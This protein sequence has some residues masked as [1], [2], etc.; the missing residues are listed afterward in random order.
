MSTL[1]RKY[2]LFVLCYLIAF[3]LFSQAKFNSAKFFVSFI[4]KGNTDAI[5]TRNLSFLSEA[6]LKRRALQNIPIEWSDYPVNQAYINQLHDEG[7]IVLNRSR[8]FNAVSVYCSDSAEIEKLKKLSFV[9]DVKPV[10][11]VLSSG[12]KEQKQLDHFKNTARLKSQISHVKSN[13]LLESHYGVSRYQTEQIDLHNLHAMGLKGQGIS[14]AVLDA[15]FYNCDRIS[16]FDSLRVNGQIL[17]TRDFV[18]GNDSVYEDNSHGM[19]VLSC[20]AAHSPNQFIGTAPKANYWLLRT[21]DAGSEY[22]IEEDNWVAAAEF[23]DSAGVWI[24]N[25]SLGYTVFDDPMTS[26]SY[27]DMDGNTTRI[28]KGADIAATKGILVVNSA[29]NSG[30]NSWQYIGAPADADSVLSIGAVDSLGNYAEFSSRGPS[31]DGRIKPNV[32]AMGQATWIVTSSGAIGKANGT[33]FSSPIIAGA[34]ACLWQAFPDAGNMEIYKA[35]EQSSHQYDA[36]DYKL[37]YGIP[38]FTKAFGILKKARNTNAGQDSLI[39]VYPNPPKETIMLEF[40]SAKEQNIEL[41]ITKVSGKLVKQTLF[42]VLPFF[43]NTVQIELPKKMSAGTYIL[44]VKNEA[45]EQFNR[46]ILLEN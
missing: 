46:R 16:L 25:S 41:S 28:S 43:T 40:Y 15:G 45:G 13:L 12:L 35:I 3:Q 22:I 10:S 18:Q 8:W 9:A 11:K 31:S 38:N 32:S 2:Y 26:H 5:N 29:G 34:A 44:S 19:S 36:P 23:A 27:S 42:K 17:G 30:N 4:D 37:G 33:S 39:N 24:I 6:A 14:I 20:M 21:E 7:F 1:F